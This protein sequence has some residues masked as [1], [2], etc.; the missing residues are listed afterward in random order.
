MAEE[1]LNGQAGA[2][3]PNRD[4]AVSTTRDKEVGEWLEVKAVDAI[5]VLAIL[6]ANLKG[7][8]IKE[9]D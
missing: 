8:Q 2:H 1:S 6:L 4:R 7:V 9:L 3:V 5:S